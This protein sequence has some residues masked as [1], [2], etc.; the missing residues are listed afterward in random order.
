M[1][2]CMV[3]PTESGMRTS[4]LPQTISVGGSRS[5]RRK[6]S[7]SRPLVIEPTARRTTQPL[8]CSFRIAARATNGGRCFGL[9]SS[10]SVR[11]KSS[12]GVRRNEQRGIEGR[13]KVDARAVVKHQPVHQ[14]GMIERELRRH[15]SAHR[16]AADIRVRHMQRLHEIDDELLLEADGV[17]DIRPRRSAVSQKVRRIDVKAGG[18]EARNQRPPVLAAGAETVQQHQRSACAAAP[19]QR[20]EV[21]HPVA[22]HRGRSGFGR[23]APKA[24]TE[25]TGRPPTAA[26]DKRR[27]RRRSRISRS[28]RA[29]R[30][31]DRANREAVFIN[32]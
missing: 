3:S 11:W 6:S 16:P 13:G 21:V 18:G 7:R 1:S 14:L 30:V 32:S 28:T 17:V 8:R 12:D 5:P 19:R 31:S 20:L 27:L 24:A 15:P 25:G 22:I 2:R 4:L 26:A 23:R 29:E 10:I 9:G